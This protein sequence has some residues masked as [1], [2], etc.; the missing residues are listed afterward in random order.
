MKPIFLTAEALGESELKL[1]NHPPLVGP[2]GAELIRM[3][4]ESGIIQLTSFD[5]DYIHRYY[6]RSDP[7]CIDA[8]WKLHPEVHRTN[9]FNLH[10]PGNNIE[11]LCGPKTSALPGY[12]PLLKSKYL[13]ADFEPELDRLANEIL[14]LDPNLIICLGNTPLWALTGKTGISKIRGTTLLST[15]TVADFKLLATYHP[16][17]VTRDWSLRP[18]VIADLMKARRESAFPEIRRPHREIWIEPTVEDIE[19]FIHAHIQGCNI[20][21]VDI[22]TAGNQVTCIGFS[23][24]ADLALVIPIVDSRRL[25]RNYWASE[26]DEYHVW[27]LIRRVLGDVS[28]PKVFQNGLYDIAFIWRTTGIKVL[29]AEHDTMLL[30]HALQPESLKGLGFLGSIYTSEGSWKQM[31]IKHTTIKRDD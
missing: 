5:R 30:H 12:P 9:T 11:S 3:L 26:R 18:T 6:T 8:I 7:T 31:R 22:E 23:P 24:R 29:T 4:G 1:P 15:H 2:S 10:P 25:G 20:L 19:R 13:R 16:A 21:S 17:A 28:I 14:T 27:K